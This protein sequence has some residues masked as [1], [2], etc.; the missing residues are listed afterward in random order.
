MPPISQLDAHLGFWLRFV[1]SQVSSRFEKQL[2]LRGISITEWVAMRS[3]YGRE[4]TT[5]T[6]LIDALGMT[7]SAVSKVITKLEV[8]GL[9]VRQVAESCIR[10]QV[11]V[12]TASGQ[13]LLPSLALLADENDQ[14]FFG[15]M[16]E[17]SRHYLIAEMKALVQYHQLKQIPTE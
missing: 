4:I 5:H 15:H 11:L 2:A 14:F 8:K 10:E 13:Q 16:D 3:L 1:S 6:E 12:L 9:V 17:S 7:K